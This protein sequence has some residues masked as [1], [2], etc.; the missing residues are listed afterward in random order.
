MDERYL[1]R[2]VD[3][4]ESGSLSRTSRRLHIS[5]PALSKSLRLLEEQLGIK[6]FERGPRGVRVTR[7]GDVF[8][9]RARSITAEFRR[10]RE[11]LEELKGSTAGQVALGVTPGPGV[12][13]R[14]LPQAV[15][16]VAKKRPALKF[17][18]RSGTSRELLPA[19]NQGDLDILFTVLDDRVQGPDLKVQLLF[20]DHFVLVVSKR[21]PL[22]R[23]NI[24]TLNDLANYRWVLL[25]DA[26][27]LRH[28]VEEMAADKQITPK[29][30]IE[31]NSVVFVRT[32][33]SKTDYIGVLPSYAAKL[34]AEAGDLVF[35][36]LERIS[37]HRVLPRLVRPMGLVHSANT[38]LTP[39][40]Q[41]L[42]RSIT[43]VCE[44]LKFTRP[45]G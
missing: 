22:C 9:R 39:A 24:I 28:T 31:S 7:F 11:D 14:I 8:Y 13:D 6:L 12:L 45:G 2:F 38:D 43:T 23:A 18:I 1:E 29:A 16:R 26:N 10:A 37:E 5:Q 15:A 25:E 30:A 41:A 40:G 4:V 44:E 35:V 42:L 34:G 17:K 19:L 20:E 32:M 36:P 21:H 33:V 27:Q 3:V